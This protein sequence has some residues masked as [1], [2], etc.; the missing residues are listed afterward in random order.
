MKLIYEWNQQV[1]DISEVEVMNDIEFSIK[2]LSPSHF[3]DMN[4]IQKIFESNDVITDVL[5]Y[6]YTNHKYRIIVRKEYY[7]DFILQLMKNQ[8]LKKV[9]WKEE[10]P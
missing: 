10:L 6:T 4:N 9:E 8:L 5:I 1:I 3:D 2:V 7:S